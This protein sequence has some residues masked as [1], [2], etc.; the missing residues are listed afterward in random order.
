[1]FQVI[2]RRLLYGFVILNVM[3]VFLF[4]VIRLIPGDPVRVQL[5]D[6]AVSQ[7]RIDELTAQLGLDRPLW[8]QLGNW[9]AGAVQG[10]FGMSFSTGRPVGTVI[11][12]RLC[13]PS[14]WRCSSASSSGSSPPYDATACSTT[15]CG[16]A[17]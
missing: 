16:S 9:Y 17:R 14:W 4:L 2:I 7:E 6:A 13:S 1:M 8:E 11:A 12:E 10:D 15:C 3:T 5:A